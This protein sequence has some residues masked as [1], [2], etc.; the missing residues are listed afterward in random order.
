MQKFAVKNNTH[1]N[2]GF[3]PALVLGGKA[4]NKKLQV[5]DVKAYIE[6]LVSSSSN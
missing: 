4:T 3:V 2:G 6:V 5:I 1:C